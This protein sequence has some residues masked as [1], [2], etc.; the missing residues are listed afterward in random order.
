MPTI[1]RRRSRRPGAPTARGGRPGRSA[2]TGRTPA[3]RWPPSGT[4]REP[5]QPMP[6]PEHPPARCPRGPAARAR[7]AASTCVASSCSSEVS[8]VQVVALERV[9]VAGEQLA[10]R[11]VERA[12]VR[13]RRRARLAAS[14]ARAR[15]SA[16]LTD[17]TVVSSSSATSLGLPAQDLAQDQHR[18]LAGRQVLQRGDEGEP[19][20]LAGDGQV[21][22]VAVARPATRPSGIG[23]DPGG[24]GQRRPERRRRRLG[25]RPEVHRAGAALP[26]VQ[27]V[28]A[29]VGRD[30]VQPRA[31]R[32][33]ALEAVEAPP[34]PHQRL[35]HGVVGLE[36]RAQHPVA[37]AG[38]ADPILLE[39][40]VGFS[41]S[42][43]QAHH[44]NR[45]PP[46]CLPQAQPRGPMEQTGR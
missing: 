13:R 9:D 27:H 44:A 36:R 21:G 45:T 1:G 29:H 26:P 2:G 11:V 15:C 28:E 35:L 17:A 32:R 24:L 18:P 33:P 20:R 42:G 46:F 5:R 8:D 7:T 6:V 39:V 23:C 37:V 30:A 12:R 22:R 3:C 38:Q 10:L 41:D 25:G 43:I 31:D 4:R 34:R 16:L 19:D 14:V 40:D